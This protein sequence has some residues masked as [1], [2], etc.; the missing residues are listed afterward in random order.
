MDGP[1]WGRWTTS[2]IFPAISQLFITDHMIPLF[3]IWF[4]FHFPIIKCST[5]LFF[6][7]PACVASGIHFDP[8]ALRST[9]D[10]IMIG[11][12]LTEECVHGLG[13]VR[14]ERNGDGEDGSDVKVFRVA[15][16]VAEWAAI[17]HGRR[18]HKLLWLSC[19]YCSS[20]CSWPKPLSYYLLLLLYYFSFL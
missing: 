13:Q 5:F 12:V 6:L 15:V 18:Q 7:S 8:P 19:K 3:V 10:G 2:I 17:L 14:R 16:D 20:C 4:W 11:I 1:V 9:L